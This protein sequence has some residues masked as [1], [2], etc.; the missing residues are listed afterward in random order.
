MSD[1]KKLWTQMLIRI[2]SPSPIFGRRNDCKVITDRFCAAEKIDELG[3]ESGLGCGVF[4]C[5]PISSDLDLQ[6]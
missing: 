3:H 5:Q 2:L 6:D 4:L 1:R